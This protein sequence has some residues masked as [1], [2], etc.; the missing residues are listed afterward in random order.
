[1]SLPEK[2]GEVVFLAVGPEPAAPRCGRK[3]ADGLRRAAAGA[4]DASPRDTGSGRKNGGGEARR[5]G[6]R[7]A[8]GAATPRPDPTP[9]SGPSR[10]ADPARVPRAPT[11][12]GGRAAVSRPRI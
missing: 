10:A 12:S 5:R 9:R 1:M 11:L 7:E 8:R 2:L 3:E 6:A 4:E